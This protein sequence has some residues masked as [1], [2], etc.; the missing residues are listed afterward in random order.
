ME[1]M[2]GGSMGGGSM[3]QE[4]ID[5]GG[6]M[7]KESMGGGRPMEEESMGMGMDDSEPMP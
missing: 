2:D 7:E 4:S 5:G 3:E 6:S 1:S